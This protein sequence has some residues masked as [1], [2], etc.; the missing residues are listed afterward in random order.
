M[1]GKIQ[2]KSNW[3][4]TWDYENRLVYATDN[5]K[6]KVRYVFDALG[7]RVMRN[8]G[9]RGITKFNPEYATEE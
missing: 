1:F 7:R 3:D 5:R 4:Y 8:A 6:V 9:T 2:G